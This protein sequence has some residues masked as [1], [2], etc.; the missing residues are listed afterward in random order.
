M[1]RLGAIVDFECGELSLTGVDKM[2]RVGS[3]PVKRHAALT[4]F[5]EGNAGRNPHPTKQEVRRKDE[6]LPA[7]PC[8]EA[9]P[10]KEKVWIVKAVENVTV[11][12]RCQQIIVGRLDSNEKQNPLL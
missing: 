9:T 3:I 6:Q 4:V 7:S 10:S 2:L 8:Y 5:P 11:P 12:P 1:D